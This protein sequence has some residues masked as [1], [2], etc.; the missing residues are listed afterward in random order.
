MTSKLA[1]RETAGTASK[2]RYLHF[3]DID[4]EMDTPPVASCS[5]C[6]RTFLVEPNAG[7]G[8]DSVLSRI[9]T[10]FDAHNCREQWL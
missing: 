5:A 8:L 7:E 4:L 1:L 2:G 9:R 3:D 10:E 6:S